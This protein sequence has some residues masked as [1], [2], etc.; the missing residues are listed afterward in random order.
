MSIQTE[1]TSTFLE[2][3]P[4]FGCNG[5]NLHKLGFDSPGSPFHHTGFSNYYGLYAGASEEWKTVGNKLQTIIA[6]AGNVIDP[7]K[8]VHHAWRE[9]NQIC[10]SLEVHGVLE[11]V[12]KCY[13]GEYQAQLL[14]EVCQ[15]RLIDLHPL[16]AISNGI[17]D[18]NKFAAIAKI[19]DQLD[20][21]KQLPFV[22]EVSEEFDRVNQQVPAGMI[23]GGLVGAVSLYK[24]VQSLREGKKLNGLGWTALSVASFAFAAGMHK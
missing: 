3:I 21:V 14:Q 22:K 7:K 24:T 9:G 4:S 18:L 8:L 23:V 13:S 12:Q 19:S 6:Q 17:K 1:I 16:D 11:K 2:K 5:I 20:K 10:E 15:D